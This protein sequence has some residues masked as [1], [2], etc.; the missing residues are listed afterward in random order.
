MVCVPLPHSSTLSHNRQ[1]FRNKVT[2]QKM[3]RLILSATF[4]RN[5]SHSKKNPERCCHMCI[6]LHAKYLL[7]L[8]DVNETWISSTFEKYWNIKFHDNVVGIATGYALDGPGIESRW[9]A[10]FFATF[11]TGPGAHPASYWIGT[12]SLFWGLGRGVDHS[13]PSR[14]EVKERVQPYLYSPSGPSWTVLGWI[15]ST[16]LSNFMKIRQV[17]AELFHEVGLIDMKQ[18]FAFRN[19]ANAPKKDVTWIRSMAKGIMHWNGIGL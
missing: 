16:L 4:L 17:G 18:I 5:I 8:S 6:G 9:G 15:L 1:G 2:E 12:E 13:S 11:Q 14:V 3:L 10:R 7:F 19:F